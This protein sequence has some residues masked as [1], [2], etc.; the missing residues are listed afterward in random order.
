M[1]ESAVEVEVVDDGVGGANAERGSGLRGLA[2]RLSAVDG[3]LSVHSP[4]GEGT[5]V[6]ASIPCDAA[7]IVAEAAS[8]PPPPASVLETSGADR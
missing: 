6:H 5:R 2:D 3:E 4:P 8:E 1:E 7:A